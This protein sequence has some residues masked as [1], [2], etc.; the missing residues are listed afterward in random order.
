M[1]LSKMIEK[2]T[3]EKGG[4]NILGQILN[5]LDNIKDER[6]LNLVYNGIML[7]WCYKRNNCISEK[8]IKEKKLFYNFYYFLLCNLNEIHKK[9]LIDSILNSLRFSCEQTISCSILFVELFVNLENEDIEKQL[10]INILER[11]LYKPIPWGV[12]F[13][14]NSLF[15]DERF[16]KMK[17]KY[18]A[19]S[20][21]I[22]NFIK[23]LSDNK[24]KK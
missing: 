8:E 7:Y 1:E 13:T 17:E 16:R 5:Y 10:I 20:I 22:D 15:D 3:I 14:L 19:R 11:A 24:K 18:F 21:E 6:E 9:F 4:E 12:K 2:Y 23:S